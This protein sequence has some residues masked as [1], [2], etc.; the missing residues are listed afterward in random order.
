VF[1]SVRVFRDAIPFLGSGCDVFEL[2]LPLNQYI[3]QWEVE[4]NAGVVFAA[5]VWFCSL[6]C[7]DYCSDLMA[8]SISG[9]SRL[10]PVLF[11][12]QLFGS[13]PY[14]V[15]ITVRISWQDAAQKF[16]SLQYGAETICY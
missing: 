13:V 14:F 10:I 5:I 12:L 11:L 3:Y 15:L 2:C 7:V 4:I 1:E 16:S 9:K 6:F 8:R